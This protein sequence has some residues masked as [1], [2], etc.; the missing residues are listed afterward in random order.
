MVF[1]TH[2]VTMDKG[3]SNTW[4]KR[5]NN[6]PTV[7]IKNWVVNFGRWQRGSKDFLWSWW[8][9]HEHRGRHDCQRNN[10]F[11]AQRWPGEFW[12]ISRTASRTESSDKPPMHGPN[13]QLFLVTRWPHRNHE[14]SPARTYHQSCFSLTSCV[15][16]EPEARGEPGKPVT[17]NKS[18][19]VPY[20]GCSHASLR[21]NY[22][23]KQI[24][25]AKYVRSCEVLWHHIAHIAH[26]KNTRLRDSDYVCQK[27]WPFNFD[28]NITSELKM[29][30]QYKG[31]PMSPNSCGDL[32][33]ASPCWA[34]AM[35]FKK[36][37]PLNIWEFNRQTTELVKPPRFSF[38]TSFGLYACRLMCVFPSASVIWPYHSSGHLTPP[39][40]KICEEL[41]M[42][43]GI[44]RTAGNWR[45]LRLPST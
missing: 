18:I 33:S 13:S 9:E 15:L 10:V 40:Y 37:T 24:N 14:S 35:I 39:L 43:F 12:F 19:P 30:Q 28:S 17:M 4:E 6:G 45:T 3:W 5:F 26:N 36:V 2:E 23:P 25:Q 21:A 34:H 7:M 29:A 38:L 32:D 41:H 11:D 44:N 1:T 8:P 22:C 27:C 16:A 42:T 20:C 31:S